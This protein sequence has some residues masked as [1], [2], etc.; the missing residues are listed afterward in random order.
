[1][2]YL[3]LLF[4]LTIF[5]NCSTRYVPVETVRTN[6]VVVKGLARDSI[7][8]KDSVFVYKDAD[9]VYNIRWQLRYRDRVIRDTVRQLR[10]D[11]VSVVVEVEKRLT[12]IQSLQM[13]IGNGVMWA[14]P[15][16]IGLWV[17]YRKLIK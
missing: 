17:F 1:M 6:E 10:C 3:F 14:V 7:F 16:I 4:V 13:N 11:T 12:R 15:V 2:R 5:V 9:T 8:V